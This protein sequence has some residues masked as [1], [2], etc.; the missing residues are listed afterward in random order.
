MDPKTVA[1]VIPPERTGLLLPNSALSSLLSSRLPPSVLGYSIESTEVLKKGSKGEEFSR[2][3]FQLASQ[4]LKS[5]SLSL[6]SSRF[7]FFT[8]Q[9]LGDFFLFPSDTSRGPKD[10]KVDVDS[11]VGV[12][13]KFSTYRCGVAISQAREHYFME[14]SNLYTAAEHDGR[15]S[16][17]L[18]KFYTIAR[19]SEVEV[20]RKKLIA[21]LDQHWVGRHRCGAVSLTGHICK[22][23]EHAITTKE[24]SN[25]DVKEH[26]TDYVTTGACNCGKSR[27]SRRDPFTIEEANQC[28]FRARCCTSFES[29]PLPASDEGWSLLILGAG[30]AYDQRNGLGQDGF[31]TRNKFLSPFDL[32]I[33]SN[34]TDESEFPALRSN[35]KVPQMNPKARVPVRVTGGFIGYE[36]ECTVGHR[37]FGPTKMIVENYPPN[38]TKPAE[39]HPLDMNAL[40]A[41]MP[42]YTTCICASQHPLS[43]L[44]MAKLQRIFLCTP[45]GVD[46]HIHPTVQ[47]V[48]PIEGLL[49]KVTFAVNTQLVIPQDH[50]VCLRVSYVYQFNGKPLLQ[51]SEAGPFKGTFVLS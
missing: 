5:R 51:T 40:R 7:W 20:Y 37:F 38:V 26:E 50:F 31:K 30:A 35:R 47:L 48:G 2:F 18:R 42:L 43:G 24:A 41:V 19:G 14:L 9:M 6:P 32:E 10:T 33:M 36:Y 16:A 39:N 4:T 23:P 3:V 46:I 28:F 17:A 27:R 21:D 8:S 44:L 1:L 34:T 25:V 29:I 13:A 12:E 49:Q 22:H 11:H 45:R 15:K